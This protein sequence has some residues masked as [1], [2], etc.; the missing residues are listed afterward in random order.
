MTRDL[1]AA[2]LLAAV[3]PASPVSAEPLEM[4]LHDGFDG[5]DFAASGGLY[6]KHTAEQT[7]G[8]VEFQNEVTYSGKGALKLT[9]RPS[10]HLAGE[11]C[12]ERAEIWEKTALRVPYFQPVWYGFAVKFADPVPED[13][14]R[15]LIAQWKREIHPGAPGDFSPF[16]ALRL[17]NGKLFVTVE[18][19]FHPAVVAGHKGT[20]ARC[21]DGLTPVWLRP[22]TNQMRA[23]VAA[24]GNWQPEDGKEF[25][26]CTDKISVIGRGNPLPSPH[27][28]WIDFAIMTR[29]GPHGDGRIE[30][31]ANNKWITTIKGHIGHD[32]P[33]LGDHQ[34]FK[35]GPYRA[36]GT[37]AW[38]LYYD[39]F[40]R[41]PHCSDVLG[42]AAACAMMR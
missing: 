27:S 22:G 12:S 42:D 29:P 21:G 8:V 16:L 19:N 39:D 40:R 11:D 36:P 2:A 33:P 41:G 25:S 13:N 10:C 20:P 24:D 34:Y 3:L 4:R 17:R 38:S 7:A 6:F 32:D 26:A 5:Q 23:L 9:V 1:A 31:F 18:T 35:F 37:S 30:I 28:G 15:Y 14:H